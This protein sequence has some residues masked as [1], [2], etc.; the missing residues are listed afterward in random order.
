M[1]RR[2]SAEYDLYRRTSV[3]LGH[4]MFGWL[5]DLF[6]PR[7][8]QVEEAEVVPLPAAAAAHADQEADRPNSKAA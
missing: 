5:R 8:P 4:S 7:R 6:R 2:S 3:R 1:C